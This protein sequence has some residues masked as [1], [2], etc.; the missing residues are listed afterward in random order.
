[1]AKNK[2]RKIKKRVSWGYSYNLLLLYIKTYKKFPALNTVY[3]NQKIARWFQIQHLTI[4]SKN[5]AMYKR[6]SKNQILKSRLDNYLNKKPNICAKSWDVSYSALI[7]YV[8]EYNTIPKTNII[9][10]DVNIYSWFNIQ[11][12]KID[13]TESIVY[14]K[15]TTNSI[16]KQN[17]DLYLHKK[18]ND[19]TLK[20]FTWEESKNLLFEY[21]EKYNK[22]PKISDVYRGQKLLSFLHDQKRRIKNNDSHIYKELS[23][24]LIIK[25][26]L[27][28]YLN[29]KKENGN[30]RPT[31]DDRLNLLFEYVNIHNKLPITRTKYKNF[32]LGHWLNDAKKKIIDHESEYYKKLSVNIIIKKYLDKYLEKINSK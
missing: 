4:K 29:M 27:D 11:K 18:N 28:K 24:L 23:K 26:V 20:K 3:K 16:V 17:I 30:Y 1:M 15:L 10:N 6:L 7:K 9:H 22:L 21:V 12:Y 5:D 25:I 31:W 2:N 32:C 13:N 8:N 14:K 19:K